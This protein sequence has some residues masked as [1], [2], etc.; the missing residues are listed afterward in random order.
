MATTQ[1]TPTVTSF[2][3]RGMTC[4]SCRA[5]ARWLVRPATPADHRGTTSCE[6]HRPLWERRH[7]TP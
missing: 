3:E 1:N 7:T 4:A 5:A 6:R 2:R